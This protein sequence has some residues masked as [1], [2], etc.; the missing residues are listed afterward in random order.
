MQACSEVIDDCL[1]VGAY[2]T[3]LPLLFS[4]IF[5]EY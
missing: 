2:V 4:L 1:I 5:W 3:Q